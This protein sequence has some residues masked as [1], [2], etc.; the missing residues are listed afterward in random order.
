MT[1]IHAA[2]SWEE[3]AKIHLVSV[4]EFDD[5]VPPFVAYCG[6]SIPGGVWDTYGARIDCQRCHVKAS[7]DGRFHAEAK[8]P[9]CGKLQ[10]RPLAHLI[11]TH[12]WARD[13]ARQ[14]VA[15]N[16]DIVGRGIR[17]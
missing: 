5:P 13:A 14:W 15:A 16:A 6:Q 11:F 7:K 3:S 1:L 17:R 8:C 9:D 2:I 10:T 4:D 12:K